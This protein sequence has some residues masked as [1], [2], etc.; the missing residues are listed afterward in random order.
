MTLPIDIIIHLLKKHETGQRLR[1]GIFYRGNRKL[2]EAIIEQKHKILIMSDRFRML[3]KL[4]SNTHHTSKSSVVAIETSFDALPVA[5]GS[6]DVFMLSKNLPKTK[7]PVNV[8]RHLKVLMKPG[9]LLIWPHPQADTAMGN[10]RPRLTPS[11][12]SKNLTAARHDI[13]AWLMAAGYAEI[14]QHSQK[15]QG[16]I[17]WVITTGIAHKTI[18]QGDKF[19]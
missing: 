18:P 13:C 4:Y 8:L 15:K 12:M 5:P 6:L 16:L 19:Y 11:W 2:T 9:G 10:M 17:P 3:H 14:E 1:L 7:D